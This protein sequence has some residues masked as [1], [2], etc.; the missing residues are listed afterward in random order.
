MI[1]AVIYSVL[2]IWDSTQAYLVI[3]GDWELHVPFTGIEYKP[4]QLFIAVCGM[5]G[6]LSA[7]AL[8]FCPESPR[9]VLN[10]GDAKRAF[11]IVQQ[12]NRWN[13]GKS[14]KLSF[15]AI[16]ADP[17]SSASREKNN[18]PKSLWSTVWHQTVPLFKPPYLGATALICTI[19]MLVNLTAM[20]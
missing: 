13:N 10:Q 6:L 3:N 5:T 7:I 4:W 1:S 20:G 17:D 2:S 19:M 9:F 14:A 8:L 16:K 18:T 12:I 15:D 11:E